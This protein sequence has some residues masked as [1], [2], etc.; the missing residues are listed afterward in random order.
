MVSWKNLIIQKGNIVVY[1]L[2]EAFHVH[3]IMSKH[4]LNEFI[5]EIMLQLCFIFYAG[6]DLDPYT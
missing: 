2:N 1:A 4:I 5:A 6:V 3:N